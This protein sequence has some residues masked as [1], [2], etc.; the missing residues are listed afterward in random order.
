MYVIPPI[1]LR[2]TQPFG[3]YLEM[4]GQTPKAPNDWWGSTLVPYWLTSNM[5]RPHTREQWS[6]Q[7]AEAATCLHVTLHGCVAGLGHQS[8]IAICVNKSSKFTIQMPTSTSWVVPGDDR[9]EAQGAE[10]L[11]EQHA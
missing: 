4:T 1:S 9:V 11:L 2:S 3:G 5:A 6:T 7:I 10:R 8:R